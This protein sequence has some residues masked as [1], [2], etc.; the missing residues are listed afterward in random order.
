VNGL[1]FREHDA[2]VTAE[3][4]EFKKLNDLKL[5]EK[6]TKELKDKEEAEKL[7][8]EAEAGAAEKSKEPEVT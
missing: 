5:N 6:L 4:N 1:F 2:L 3:S 8:T 7:K